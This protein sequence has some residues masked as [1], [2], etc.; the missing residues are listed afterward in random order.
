MIDAYQ[1]LVTQT[2]RDLCSHEEISIL[3]N[4]SKLLIIPPSINCTLYSVDEYVTV[5]YRYIEDQLN[6]KGWDSKIVFN[7]PSESFQTMYM[8]FI[9]SIV[10]YFQVHHKDYSIENFIYITGAA[11][12]EYNRNLYLKYCELLD[13]TP[14]K[15]FYRSI[16]EN[17]LAHSTV[18]SLPNVTNPCHGELIRSDLYNGQKKFLCLNKQPRHHR[19][20]L[21]SQLIERNLLDKG[22]FS[23]N[24]PLEM[25]DL[26]STSHRYFPKIKNNL[27]KIKSQFPINLTLDNHNMHWLT[28]DDVPLY[29]NSLFSLVTET[30][31]LSS[32]VDIK[33]IDDKDVMH[34]FPSIFYTEKTWK[35]IR[36]KH[37][38]IILST[39]Y[40][41]RELR[42]LG[43]KSF[44]PYINETYDSIEDDQNRLL[45]VVDEVERLC[46]MTEDEINEWLPKVNAIAK[47]N[48]DHL[49]RLMTK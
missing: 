24:S 22:Y 33:N 38:F 44:H 42:K 34:C 5:A 31:F 1:D 36:A 12:T 13:Y 17:S 27:H 32:S 23:F 39:P 35:A 21:V 28:T 25:I 30:L 9:D 18:D 40:S 3:L 4:E 6:G 2:K 41:V 15:V 7:M 43:Y 20:A 46:N 11:D 47:F 8:F 26:C 14:I 10:K 29:L 16:F 37:P 45:A 49:L 19:A 48:Y